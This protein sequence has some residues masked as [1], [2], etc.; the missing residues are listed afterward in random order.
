ME[1]E[2]YMSLHQI[3]CPNCN[4][5]FPLET[6]I[7]NDFEATL[8]KQ[9]EAKLH[10]S[11]AEKEQNYAN[12]LAKL[13]QERKT[14]EQD[15][16]KILLMIR[17]EHK[18]QMEAERKSQ[19]DMIAKMNNDNFTRIAEER[20]KFEKENIDKID[21]ERK[22][23]DE[24]ILKIEAEREAKYE[25][26][27]QYELKEKESVQKLDEEINKIANKLNADFNAKNEWAMQ[28]KDNLI[29]EERLQRVRL[30]KQIEELQKKS[31][32]KS[33]ELQGEAMEL[34]L[35]SRLKEHF[36]YDNFQEVSK[37]IRGADLIQQVYRAQGVSAGAI[38]YEFKNAQNFSY[39]WI[40]KLK[41]DSNK[42]GGSVQ[43]LV[44]TV[45]PKEAQDERITKI[46]G[47]WVCRPEYTI[48]VATIIREQILKVNEVMASQSGKDSKMQ[49][50]YDYLTTDEFKNKFTRIL[51]TFDEM[52]DTLDSE[53]KAM[54]KHWQNRQIQIEKVLINSTEIYTKINTIALENY[55]SGLSELNALAE[56]ET[57]KLPD[58]IDLNNSSDGLF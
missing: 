8:L 26:Q 32:Q 57:K 40:T 12:E 1:P 23:N 18:E 14:K 27:K 7:S 3:T 53:K 30:Q 31:S 25:L 58:N 28:E 15:L 50:L 49:A 33:M 41:D 17:N 45:F 56:K 29:A 34:N 24:L 37:G 16:E 52:K 51:E 35:E 6:A 42:S 19:T 10:D 39:D 2:F 5:S 43:L 55:S 13:E 47:V 36:I 48:I 46:E 9:A 54:T 44:T 20:Q 22:R 21:S 11:F 4:H 38:V